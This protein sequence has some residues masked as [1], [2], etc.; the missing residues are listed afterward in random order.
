MNSSYLTA[1]AWWVEIGLVMAV[2]GGVAAGLAAGAGRWARPA[3]RL[4]AVWRITIVA[5]WTLLGVELLGVGPA[6]GLWARAMLASRGSQ[7]AQPMKNDLMASSSGCVPEGASQQ[8]NAAQGRWQRQVPT[9]PIVA[10]PVAG[11]TPSE[12]G[13][14]AWLQDEGQ[15]HQWA[16]PLGPTPGA[17]TD[18]AATRPNI[19]S[20]R[21][22]Q[23][24]QTKPP[25]FS[26]AVRML[27]DREGSASGAERRS[28]SWSKPDGQSLATGRGSGSRGALQAASL[29]TAAQENGWL[30]LPA[31]RVAERCGTW[32]ARFW[33]LGTV[34]LLGWLSW[35][36]WQLVRLRAGLSALGSR[37]VAERAHRLAKQLGL[38]RAVEL[39][40]SPQVRSPVAF[41][42]FRP[43]LV[44][45]PG[46]AVEFEAS[47]QEVMLAH[48]LAH[49]AHRDPL[50]L[51][52]CDALCAVLWWHPAVWAIRQQLRRAS[53]LAAD[54]SSL[55]VPGGPE[56]LA[57]CLVDL[58]RRTVQE[59]RL[60][61]L[62]VGGGGVRSALGQ[63]VERLLGLRPAEGD[64]APRVVHP[65]VSAGG[66]VLAVAVL[67]LSLSWVHAQ[68]GLWQGETTMSVLQATW[69]RSLAALAMAAFLGPAP[70][71]AVAA[72][73]P[74]APKAVAPREGE[75]AERPKDAPR[76]GERRRAE[77]EGRPSPEM[78]PHLRELLQR[79]EQLEREAREI[80]AQLE[81]AR[82]D[83]DDARELRGRLE[84]IRREIA[85]I[86][87]QLPPR[88]GPR[89]EARE[90]PRP[91]LPPHQRALPE[92]LGRLQEKAAELRAQLRQVRPDSDD[93]RVL[94]EK[95]D[96]LLRE[97]A[98]IG[99]R[100]PKPPHR[101]AGPPGP[102]PELGGP[103][104]EERQRRMHH[105]RAAAENLRAAGM[106][107]LADRLLREAE[108]RR[109][110]GSG[111]MPP[112]EAPDLARVVHE[113][114]GQ[115]Q[116]LRREVEELRGQ[117]R[118]L[119]HE[120]EEEREKPKEKAE[121]RR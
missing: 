49:L 118:R 58:A 7:T 93:A 14:A 33:A 87:R 66:M 92:Q 76:E 82:P 72:E 47:Q 104:P 121:R 19:V 81:R 57:G 79:R 37:P 89:R 80:G 62:G 5:V 22:P 26:A 51:V 50:W 29:P 119:Q 21:S 90:G 30:M 4:Q 110:P 43:A 18:K 101:L 45:P 71:S 6:L 97:M 34:A 84:R 95:L 12:A 103:P 24:V 2:G 83:S 117:V 68:A 48:E 52:V 70:A 94:R 111:P 99:R 53:E 114:T 25:A 59:R 106:H 54:E 39:L 65:G 96:G 120:E 63:R 41:G 27:A 85:E 113:L 88:E 17:A 115:V 20:P 9:L 78:P 55:L 40:E 73:H 61:W 13:V 102:H 16:G 15:Q 100:M 32:L 31:S 60:V 67:V 46:F 105:V 109:G 108:G 86:S 116:Q 42:V 98:E 36:R 44:V 8:P 1:G 28:Q 56:V 10:S 75:R 77:R 107:E 35:N 91:E 64:G 112:P 23:V 38:R 11:K 74:D 3:R 69:Q